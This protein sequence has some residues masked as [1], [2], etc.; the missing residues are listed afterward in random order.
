MKEKKPRKAV[1]ESEIITEDDVVVKK[2]V[3]KKSKVKPVKNRAKYTSKYFKK[4]SGRAQDSYDEMLQE[5]YRSVITRAHELS[6][7][8]ESDYQKLI[9]ITVPD[10]FD[11]NSKVAYRLDKKPNGS[12][13]LLY[14]Q[15]LVTA[16]FFGDDSLFY[17]QANVDHRNGHIAYDVSGE[18]NYFDVVHMETAF[19]YDHVIHPKYL[20]LDL[21]VTLVDGTKVPFHLRNHRI[22]DNYDLQ[23]LLTAQEK[24]LLDTLKFKVRESRKAQA[25]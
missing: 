16:V 2:E 8:Q 25:N 20:T 4:F 18:F 1:A 13:T 3:D 6:S 5:D 11:H 21:E 14:D 17:H 19:K 7:I 10:A 24:D 23:Q 9:L 22:H 12:Y 15:A